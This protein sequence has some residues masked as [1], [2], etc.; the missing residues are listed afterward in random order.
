M[1]LDAAFDRAVARLDAD[2]T[3]YQF[4][5]SR[6]YNPYPK[7]GTIQAS[8]LQIN[9]ADDFINPPELGISDRDIR[10][11]PHGSFVPLPITEQ[12]RGHGTHTLPAIWQRSLKELLQSSEPEP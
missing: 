10:L 9:S 12:P 7:L 3:V 8:L 2:D 1:K 4:D 6:N 11:V 5:T